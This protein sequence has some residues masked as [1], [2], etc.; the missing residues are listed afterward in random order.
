MSTICLNSNHQTQVNTIFYHYKKRD[1]STNPTKSTNETF[2][3][4]LNSL[5]TQK[6]Q[7]IRR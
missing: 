6:D 4:H 5:N 3:S 1:W 2:T 7:D